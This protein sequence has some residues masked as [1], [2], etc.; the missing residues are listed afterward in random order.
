MSYLPDLNVDRAS[1]AIGKT[2]AKMTYSRYVQ[3]RQ[4]SCSPEQRDLTDGE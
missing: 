2:R 4:V 3:R 1:N